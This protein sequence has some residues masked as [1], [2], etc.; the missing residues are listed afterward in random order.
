MNSVQ[1]RKYI[2]ELLNKSDEPQKGHV[3]AE[4]LG[5]TR[6]II[7]KDIAIL[8]A[9]GKKVIATPDGYII[10]R[11]DNN[12][13]RKV[14]AVS[15]KP[16]DIEDELETI[17]KYGGIVEDVIVE[18]KIYGEIKAMLMLKNFYDIENF[19]INVNKYNSEPLLILTGGLHLHTISAENH[20][21][22]KNILKELK[23]K[24]YLVSD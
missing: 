24:N 3:I 15:H 11:Q 10:P 5:V 6:Q 20:G 17:I 1:R 16:A 7:V 8:R 13:V 9:E 18:H 2:E 19:M 4:K 22:I 14:I 23:I 21:I 12:L